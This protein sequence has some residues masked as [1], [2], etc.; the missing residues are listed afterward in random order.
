MKYDII[1]LLLFFI[2]L[3]FV[4]KQITFKKDVQ[5]KTLCKK[6]YKN[7]DKEQMKKLDFLRDGIALNYQNHWYALHFTMHNLPVALLVSLWLSSVMKNESSLKMLLNVIA[8]QQGRRTERE[9]AY[10][11]M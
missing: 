1:I 10:M 2:P 3:N 8:V 5:C 4:L 9:F 11:Y 7:G 6:T